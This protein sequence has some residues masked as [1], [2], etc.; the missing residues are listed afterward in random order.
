MARSERFRAMIESQMKESRTSR[1]EINDPE[2][3]VQTYYLLIE[4]IYEGECDLNG[5]TIEEMLAL[6][7]LTDEYLLADLQKVCEETIIET[8]DGLGA[9]HILT[10]SNVL[11]PTAAEMSIKDVAKS[12]LLDEYETVEK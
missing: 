12:V 7:K 1:V 6:L 3:S 8:M 10:E 9:L 4:W 2:L 11:I 5:C